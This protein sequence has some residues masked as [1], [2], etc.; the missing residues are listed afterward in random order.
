MRITSIEVTPIDLKLQAP[1]TVAYGSY[2]VLEYALLKVFTDDG[3]VGLGEAAPDPEVTGEIRAGVVSAI[4][5]LSGYLCG[6][7]PFDIEAVITHC[8]GAIPAYPA[9][10]A[11]VDMALRDLTGKAVGVP[12]YRMLGGRSREAL[13]LYPVIPLDTPQAMA[14]MASYFSGMGLS[15][16]KVKLGTDPDLDLERIAAIRAAARSGT[17]LRLDI[18]QGWKDAATAIRAIRSF[19]RSG[20]DWIEQPV[21]AADIDGLAEVS[22]AFD[23]PIMADE[24]C[25]NP[26]DVLRI[27][28]AGAAAMINIKLMKCGGIGQALKMLAI[29]EA[30]GIRC[31]LGSMGESSIGSAAGLHL[32]IAR[33]GLEAS[34]IIGPLFITN[35]PATGFDVD[36]AS[37]RALPSERPGLGVSLR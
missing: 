4:E 35:D 19:D 25:H 12:V 11:A 10:I 30:A 1:L 33:L 23:T 9:A 16:L 20:I 14:A 24:S 2:P 37:F 26:T 13:S 29:A 15:T 22:A 5:S 27:A 32:A 28:K 31:I 21:A 36:M 8:L 7:D 34:E 6:K 18:N 3:R 17:R